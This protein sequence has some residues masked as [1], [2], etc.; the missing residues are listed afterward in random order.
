MKIDKFRRGRLRNDAYFQF[1][2]EFRDL[3]V[4]EGA[5]NLKIKEQFDEYLAL[6]RKVDDGLKKINKSIYTEQIREADKARDEIYAAMVETNSAALKHY[7]PD[8]KNA[9]KQLKI[10][11]DTYGN[12]TI[13]TYNEQTSAIYNLLQELNAK[14]LNAARLV[15]IE[16][17]ADELERRNI[18]F[19][20]LM[21]E[22]FDESASGTNINLRD[23]RI[24]ADVV[25]DVIVERLN[26]RSV[27]DSDERLERFIRTLN[28]IISKYGGKSPKRTSLA[29]A[30]ASAEDTDNGFGNGGGGG[31]SD[32]NDGYDLSAIEEYNPDKHYTEYKLGDLVKHEGIIF[33][34][35]DL[36]QI[37]YPPYSKLGPL[38]WERVN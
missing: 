35:K 38:G 4:K 27:L 15:A 33:R 24:N 13:R 8:I 26:A 5:Q 37:Q 30:Q 23:A 10:L 28:V 20:Q 12:V 29:T 17:W 32:E 2:T 6:Y 9:A 18:A 1:N 19:D 25:Y 21:K 31:N 22:R 7:V 36:G 14:Y 16:G 3:I 34:V 11:F